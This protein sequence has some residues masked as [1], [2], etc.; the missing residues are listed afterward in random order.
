M[1]HNITAIILKGKFDSEQVSHFDLVPVPLTAELTLFHIDTAYVEYWQSQLGMEGE[2]PDIVDPDFMIPR[3]IVL[4]EIMKFITGTLAPQYA[5]IR[6]DYFG[7]TGSQYANVFIGSQN[8]DPGM[9]KINQALR[10]LGV[11][12]APGMDEFD[13]V[14]LSDI[15]RMPSYLEKYWDM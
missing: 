1:G 12:A 10:Y 2:L 14:G 6:T 8:V 3:E 11:V 7:G 15:R 5:I 9:R 13:T 4:A